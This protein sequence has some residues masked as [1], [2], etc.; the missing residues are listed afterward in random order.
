VFADG[1]MPYGAPLG[2]TAPFGG[3]ESY[4]RSGRRSVDPTAE[5]DRLSL[6][7]KEREIQA[8]AKRLNAEREQIESERRRLQDER[9]RW[10]E[11]QER[12]SMAGSERPMPTYHD[13]LRE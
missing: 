4:L 12:M 7:E 3:G 2:V 1:F 5:M 13:G 10:F 8:K 9:R 11:E 6:H